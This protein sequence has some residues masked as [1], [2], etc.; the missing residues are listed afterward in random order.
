MWEFAAALLL[1]DVWPDESL[2]LVAILGFTLSLS[3]VLFSVPVGA[4][5]DKTPRLH[6]AHQCPARAVS[7]LADMG[8]G[9][10]T[11]SPAIKVLIAYQNVAVFVAAASIFTVA[12]SPRTSVLRTSNWLLNLMVG[13]TILASCVA[14]VYSAG[15]KVAVEKDWVVV[16]TSGREDVLAGAMRTA[17]RLPAAALD[18]FTAIAFAAARRC[19]CRCHRRVRRCERYHA[20]D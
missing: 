1:L 9:I 18:A 16:L 14:N 12:A 15:E 3:V 8:C 4:W 11:P 13:V 10:P 7:T 5:L 6:G 19:R 17:Q 20:T 2:R